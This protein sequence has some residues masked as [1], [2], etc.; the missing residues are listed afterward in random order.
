MRDLQAIAATYADIDSRLEQDR[1]AAQG[2]TADLQRIDEKQRFNDQAYFILCWGQFEAA[3]DEACR[4]LIRRRQASSRWE[5]RRA[6][7]LYNPDDK[8]LSGLSFEERVKLILDWKG[9][10]S[11]AWSLLLGYYGLRNQIAH[12]KVR[13]HRIDV[14][15]VVGDLYLIQGAFAQ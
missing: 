14:S 2:N 15:T 9:P 8:R 3:I 7:D 5:D 6:W 12:G 11:R 13:P 10:G 4:T 1:D